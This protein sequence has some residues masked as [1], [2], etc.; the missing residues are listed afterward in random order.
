MPPKG[1]RKDLVIDTINILSNNKFNALNP[2]S[3]MLNAPKTPFKKS[4]YIKSFET[5]IVFLDDKVFENLTI[6]Q[7]LAAKDTFC[8]Q[9]SQYFP[10]IL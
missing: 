8:H 6:D 10:N 7:N 5:P 3:P 4:Q 1:K 9:S 2:A